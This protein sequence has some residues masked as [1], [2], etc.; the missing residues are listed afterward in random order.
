MSNAYF[1]VTSGNM[2]PAVPTSFVTD[3]STTAVPAANLL[4]VITRDTTDDNDNGIQTTADPDNGDNLYVENTNRATGITTTSD[5]TPTTV[6]TLPMGATPATYF[7]WGNGVAFN[8]S[9]P[10]GSTYGYR[11]GF[12]TTGAAGVELGTEYNTSFSDMALDDADITLSVSG[13]DIIV[14]VTGVSGLSVDWNV[15]FEFRKVT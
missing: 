8:S 6:I 14:Q 15:L 1:L 11:G 3:D 9:S 2:P 10:A 4:N 13:N 5:D 12:R 7:V